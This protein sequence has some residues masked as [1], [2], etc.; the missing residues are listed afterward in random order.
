MRFYFEEMEIEN[1]IYNGKNISVCNQNFYVRNDLLQI[2]CFQFILC[3]RNFVNSN[4]KYFFKIFHDRLLSKYFP[5]VKCDSNEFFCAFEILCFQNI[6]A[7]VH[8]SMRSVTKNLA[9]YFYFKLNY[10]FF[11]NLQ[12]GNSVLDLVNKSF[13]YD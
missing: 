8:F 10:Y 13:A 5:S 4:F 3:V 11:F 1:Y 12:K 9:F 2:V 6:F 7:L